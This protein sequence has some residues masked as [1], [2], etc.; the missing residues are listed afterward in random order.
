MRIMAE[1]T[2]M[3]SGGRHP[4]GIT[5]AAL[6][7]IVLTLLAAGGIAIRARTHHRYVP[8]RAAPSTAAQ[9]ALRPA[10]PRRNEPPEPSNGAGKWCLEGAYVVVEDGTGRMV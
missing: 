7:P 9:Q 8:S 5:R 2:P 3:A 4:A 10:P 6:P 1:P